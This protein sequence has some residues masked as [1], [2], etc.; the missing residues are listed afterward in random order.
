MS[1]PKIQL[2]RSKRMEHLD[3]MGLCRAEVSEWGKN[4]NN[5][6]SRATRVKR[7]C[8]LSFEDYTM[9]AAKAGIRSASQIGIFPG[10]Y[11]MGRFGDVGGYVKGNCRFIVKEQNL[12]ERW[13]YA[14]R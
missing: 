8:D 5:L 4:W 7:D 3:Q 1:N 9:L 2:L 12:K 13:L 14:K 10:A 6:R 11:Q